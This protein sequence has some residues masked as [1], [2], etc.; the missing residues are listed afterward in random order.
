MDD[1]LYHI[2]T[3]LDKGTLIKCL[4]VDKRWNAIAK[5]GG[6]WKSFCQKDYNKEC[7]KLKVET[8]YET[9]IHCHR[10]EKLKKYLNLEDMAISELNNFKVLN[11]SY[12]KIKLTGTLS[13]E[14]ILLTNLTV[15]DLGNN[16]LTSISKETARGL[17]NL[18][19]LDF[20]DNKLTEI[21]NEIY[22]LTNLT[23]LSFAHNQI[24]KISTDISQL[25]NLRAL[26]LHH[27]NLSHVPKKIARLTKLERLDLDNNFLL[28]IPEEIKQMTNLKT[29]FI[30]DINDNM[31]FKNIKS[32]PYDIS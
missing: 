32:N 23:Y 15:L 14:I 22:Q 24:T 2:F 26:Y 5:S 13:N 25:T 31:R 11:L 30:T 20:H 21:P 19:F 9:Y 6:I 29:L 3:L 28:K 27:N 4:L 1:I 18:G 10:L 8:W 17:T 7:M 16:E 12:G